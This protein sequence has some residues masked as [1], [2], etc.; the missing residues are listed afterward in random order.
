MLLVEGANGSGLILEQSQNIIT[1]ESI[2]KENSNE[3]RHFVTG[4][5]AEAEKQLRNPRLYRK[6]ILEREFNKFQYLIDQRISW[7]ELKH[8][9][10]TMIDEDRVC[11]IIREIYWDGNTLLGK[12]ELLDNDMGRKALSFA[13]AGNAG[14]STRGTGSVKNGLVQENFSFV[15]WD[16]VLRPSANSVLSYVNENFN[17]AVNFGTNEELLFKFKKEIESGRYTNKGKK[18]FEESIT[19]EFKKILYK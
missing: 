5:F 4:V 9:N 19:E 11:M 1:L 7:G 16:F 2:N 3:K 10:H 12:A 6:F 17:E 13:K 15:T 14:V 8:P 18:S